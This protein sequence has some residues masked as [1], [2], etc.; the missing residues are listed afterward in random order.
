[1]AI[2]VSACATRDTAEESVRLRDTHRQRFEA[3]VVHNFLGLQEM[4]AEDLVYVHSDGKVETKEEFIGRIRSGRIKYRSIDA[5]N[6][7]IRI[8]GDTGVV[9]GRGAF[10]VT[11]D[12]VERDVDLR[13]TAVYRRSGGRWRLVS[14]QSTHSPASPPWCTS[15]PITRTRRT[16]YRCW[17]SRN[18]SPRPRRCGAT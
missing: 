8:Y 2:L 6:P 10:A 11:V 7:D 3:M 18:N 13:Y 1:M 5:P 9:T 15:A 14:W 12:K 16:P 4:L 17:P